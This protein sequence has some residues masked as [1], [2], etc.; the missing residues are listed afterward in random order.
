MA[1][2][3]I[4]LLNGTSSAG[5]TTL[6][7]A[8]RAQLA[9]P[10]CLYASDQL[11]DAGFRP[12]APHQ[13]HAGRERFFDGFHRSIPA[14]AAAGND[15]IIE[16][17]VES[18][19]WADQLTAL[20]GHLDVFWVGVH[21]P[22]AVIEQRE[23]DRGNRQPGEAAYH[24]KTHGYCRYDLEVDTSSGPIDMIAADVAAAWRARAGRSKS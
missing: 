1:D 22:L 6:S 4:I 24:L 7:H 5:K 21:A 10:F 18:Q 19:A 23:R 11:A 9:E 13:R 15:L 8:L 2:G 17:I 20:I 16:H 12:T 14:F 3:R